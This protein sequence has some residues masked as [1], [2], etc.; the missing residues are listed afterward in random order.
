MQ[1]LVCQMLIQLPYLSIL[2]DWLV[3]ISILKKRSTT[4]HYLLDVNEQSNSLFVELFLL[5][6]KCSLLLYC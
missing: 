1:G 6:I 3:F 4:L 5:V 2:F